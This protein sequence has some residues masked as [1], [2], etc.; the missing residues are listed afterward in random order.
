M[1]N[2]TLW[3]AVIALVGTIG[4]AA[5]NAYTTLRKA[6]ADREPNAAELRAQ[7]TAS[8]EFLLTLVKFSKDEVTRWKDAYD[9]S[10]TENIELKRQLKANVLQAEET[11]ARMLMAVDYLVNLAQRKRS[12]TSAEV[13][14]WATIALD[15]SMPRDQFERL[16]QDTEDFDDTVIPN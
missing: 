14:R 13:V 4:T 1:N 15:R 16:M 6:R 10:S 3:V 8:N 7:D 5:F 12:V 11:E 2:P 9:A